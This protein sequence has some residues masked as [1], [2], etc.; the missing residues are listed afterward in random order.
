MLLVRL[1]PICYYLPFFGRTSYHECNI[2]HELQSLHPSLYEL[3]Q[4]ALAQTRYE[5]G[6]WNL[7]C[8]TAPPQLRADDRTS[9]GS[10]SEKVEGKK[11]QSTKTVAHLRP[12]FNRPVPAR[13]T[14]SH[15][16]VHT[17]DPCQQRGQRATCQTL[18]NSQRV[19]PEDRL[20]C[21]LWSRG[22]GYVLPEGALV[23][24]VTDVRLELELLSNIDA[25]AVHK[26]LRVVWLLHLRGGTK[27]VQIGGRCQ[28]CASH[29]AHDGCRRTGT[30]VCACC[31]PS[32]L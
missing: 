3:Q 27:R 18:Q 10:D 21:P 24:V 17:P 1:V 22:R 15:R 12:I 8:T 14:R 32:W 9:E 29:C 5:S 28:C 20:A 31:R 13:W 30:G 26:V 16:T 23:G 25:G 6:S 19:C 7:A 4:S 2:P 11:K